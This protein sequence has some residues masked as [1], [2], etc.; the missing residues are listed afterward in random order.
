M[1]KTI[2]FSLAAAGLLIALSAMGQTTSPTPTPSPSASVMHDKDHEGDRENHR[3][4]TNKVAVD[5]VCMQSAVD[6]RDNA[7]VSAVDKYFT[8]VKAA[9]AARRDALKA[10]WALTDA[11]ASR[12]ARNDAWDLYR[13]SVKTARRLLAQDKSAAWKQFKTDSKTCHANGEDNDNGGEGADSQI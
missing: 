8:S 11:K 10:A 12:K 2:S 1:N 4:K 7:L 5:R 6:K 13:K 3:D 9:L